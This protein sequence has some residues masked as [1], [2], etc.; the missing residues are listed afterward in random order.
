M[1]KI[2]VTVFKYEGTC[3]SVVWT[4]LFSFFGITM[5]SLIIDDAETFDNNDVKSLCRN[6]YNFLIDFKQNNVYIYHEHLKNL[7]DLEKNTLFI[8]FNHLQSHCSVTAN[9]FVTR[10]YSVNDIQVGLHDRLSGVISDAIRELYPEEDHSDLKLRRFHVAVDNFEMRKG[11]R[12]LTMQH[13][14]VLTR[15]SG[16]VVRTYPVHPEL[17]TGTFTCEQCDTVVENVEQHFKYTLPVRCSNDVCQNRKRFKLDVVRSHFYDYQK[18]RI[19][20]MQHELP[21]G[22]VPRSMDVIVRGECVERCQPGDRFDFVGTMIVVPDVSQLSLPGN[23]GL[24]RAARGKAREGYSVEGIRGLKA[25]GVRDLNY[26][27]AFLACNLIPLDFHLGGRRNDEIKRGILLMLFGGVP[28][29]TVEGTTLRGDINICI[30]GDPSTAKSQFLKQVGEFCPRAVYTTGRSS[31]AAGLTAAVIRD[32]ESFEFVIEAGALILADNGICCIDEFD[33]METK[34]QVAIHEAM[35]QQTISITKAGVK[36]TLNA[37]TSILAAA[38]PV[39][40]AYDRTKSLRQNVNLSAPILSRFDLFFVIVDECNELVDYSIGKQILSLHMK[41]FDEMKRVYSVED[42]QRYLMFTRLWNPRLSEAA[43]EC[44]V[45]NY[46]RL[47]I[48]DSATPTSAWS[49]LRITVRQLESMI[50]LSEAVAR[51][52]CCDTINKYFEL[53]SHLMVEVKHV[54]EAVRLLN[55]SIVRVEQPDVDLNEADLAADEEP[56]EIQE[57]PT[58]SDED[59]EQQIP[60]DEQSSQKLTMSFEEYRR[61][62]SLLVMHLRSEEE[63][64]ESSGVEIGMRLTDLIAW[65]LT[66]TCN[67]ID[68]EEELLETKSLVEKIVHRLIHHD[69]VLLMLTDDSASTEEDENDPII[70]VHP[71]FAFEND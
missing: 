58:P 15:I 55:K 31:S 5:A 44:L 25:L 27:V 47:R 23:K 4:V 19:Q 45:Q 62:S 11:L 41:K 42:I 13:I 63:K 59:A 6:F 29:R 8:D 65:Y 43:S 70:V 69:N 17:C 37:R 67:D 26:R 64:Q 52:Y 48:R 34:D 9:A 22:S 16:Q 50:R 18:V 12:Q 71:N 33:R 7:L 39:G 54:E 56:M 1:I 14:G 68:S 51:M 32:E 10:Y 24:V 53:S 35:E 3:F 36:A 66:E 21:R 40:G 60:S 49:S 57:K 28:K 2:I 46:K 38:N 20:E 61:I 30:V